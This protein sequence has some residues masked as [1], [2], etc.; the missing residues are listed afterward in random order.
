MMQVCDAQQY[1]TTPEEA[2]KALYELTDFRVKWSNERIEAVARALGAEGPDHDDH[3][4]ACAI[5]SALDALLAT[6]MAIFYLLPNIDEPD[7]C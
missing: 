7:Y 3:I 2:A 1:E 4:R 5:S 6:A